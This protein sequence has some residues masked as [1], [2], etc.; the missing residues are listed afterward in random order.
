[1]RR[2]AV[3]NPIISVILSVLHI[4]RIG[5]YIELLLYVYVSKCRSGNVNIS[6]TVT[7]I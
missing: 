5:N 6:I 4:L 3:T 1:M 7:T 2:K